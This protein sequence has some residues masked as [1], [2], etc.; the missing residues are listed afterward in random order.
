MTPP[1]ELHRHHARWLQ[2]RGRLRR[3]L[4]P[5]PRRANLTRYPVLK[6]F[7]VHARRAAFLWSF[8]R[9]NVIPSLYVGSV[10]AFLP[11][12]GLQILFGFGLALGVI[13]R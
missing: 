10:L 5:L 3:L 2:R 13:S 1:D 7:A 11:V 12:Y 4:R 9:A 8:K 6:W